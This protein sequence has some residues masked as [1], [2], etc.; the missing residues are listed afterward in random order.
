MKTLILVLLAL[1]LASCASMYSHAD[2]FNPCS[3]PNSYECIKWQQE[4]PKEYAKYLTRQQK[5]E[6]ELEAN[7]GGKAAAGNGSNGNQ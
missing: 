1:C 5:M 2:S 4:F 6:A 7:R 3:T